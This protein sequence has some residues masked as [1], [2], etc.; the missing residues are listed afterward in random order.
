MANDR[1]NYKQQIQTLCLLI[2][3]IALTATPQPVY[4]DAQTQHDKAAARIKDLR[5]TSYVTSRQVEQL[6]V[7]P[8]IRTKALQT[9]QR[10]GLTKL[11]L[12]VYRGGHVVSPE[13]LIFTRDWLKDM[14]IAVGGG[15]ATVPGGD[16]G[17]RQKGPLGWFNWQNEKTQRDLEKIIRMAAGIFDAFIVDDF[18]CTGD[19]SDE[20]K[21]A[22]G[23]RSWGQYR[24]ELLTELAQSVLIGPAKEVNPDI[25]MIV[26]Y[27]Q[28]SDRF[29]LFGY[30]TKTLPE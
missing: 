29:H 6:A 23:E 19:I 16:F 1:E 28:W 27:P 14:N 8:V 24:R 2:G 7:D 12:E 11:Y 5:L 30:D 13:Y 26:K 18:L 15:I 22:K 21:A 10:M 4:S 9:I 25:T 3:T 17:V 20:S